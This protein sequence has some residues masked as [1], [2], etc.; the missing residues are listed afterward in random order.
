MY[1]LVA[2]YW[3]ELIEENRVW[4]HL[5]LL[6]NAPGRI[7][8]SML[9]EIATSAS[10]AGFREWLTSIAA[11]QQLATIRRMGIRPSYDIV[12][13]GHGTRADVLKENRDGHAAPPNC[14]Q[15]TVDGKPVLAVAGGT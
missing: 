4:A 11:Q 12:F 1:P 10:D 14:M 13:D 15:V 9:T 7:S 6:Q 2:D 5:M 8:D 3:R